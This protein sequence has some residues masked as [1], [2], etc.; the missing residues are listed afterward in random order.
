[1]R[2]LRSEMHR[3]TLGNSYCARPVETDCHFESICESCTF[4]VTTIEF[5]PTL[6]RQRDDA[7]DKGQ[8]GR[9][10]IFDSLLERLDEAAS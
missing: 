4:F 9:Q 3:R 8:V 5:R 2:K 6:K 7:A 1:M 10:K